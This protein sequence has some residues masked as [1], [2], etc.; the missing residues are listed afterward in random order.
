VFSH[1]L[2]IYELFN[3]AIGYTILDRFWFELLIFVVNSVAHQTHVCDI[4]ILLN[5]VDHI[6]ISRLLK[7]LVPNFVCVCDLT[8]QQLVY[9]FFR[10]GYSNVLSF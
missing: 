4:F 6:F 2:H 9:I 10:E 8:H 3:I 1:P 5:C 7:D